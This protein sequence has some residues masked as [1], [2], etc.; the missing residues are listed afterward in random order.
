MATRTVESDTCESE[1]CAAL[2]PDAQ[3]SVGSTSSQ[4]KGVSAQ[5][6]STV[7]AHECGPDTESDPE[8]PVTRARTCGRVVTNEAHDTTS[9]SDACDI[10]NGKPTHER[11]RRRT[12]A[13]AARS[14]SPESQPRAPRATSATDEQSRQ[15]AR[16]Q[17]TVAGVRVEPVSENCSH[18]HWRFA[19][20]HT[21]EQI[22]NAKAA[23]NALVTAYPEQPAASIR[24]DSSVIAARVERRPSTPAAA[25]RPDSLPVQPALPPPQS[26]ESRAGVRRQRS[27]CTRVVNI[28]NV[29]DST[30]ASKRVSQSRAAGDSRAASVAAAPRKTSQPLETSGDSSPRSPDSPPAVEKH[31]G[32]RYGESGLRLPLFDGHDWSGFISQFEMCAKRYHWSDSV[33]VMR[34]IASIVGKARQSLSSTMM[35]HWSYFALKK[36]FET[37]YGKSQRSVPI[38]DQ[39]SEITRKTDQNLQQ[40]YDSINRVVNSADMSYE[41]RDKLVYTTFMQGLRSN[42]HMHRWVARREKRGTIDSALELAA[43]YEDEFGASVTSQPPVVTVNTRHVAQRPTQNASK[44]PDVCRTSRRV[45]QGPT[46]PLDTQITTGFRKLQKQIT[47]QFMGVNSRLRAVES[48]QRSEARRWKQ[49][50][51]TWVPRGQHRP[52]DRRYYNQ[53]PTRFLKPDRYYSYDKRVADRRTFP[54]RR[55]DGWRPNRNFHRY[56]GHE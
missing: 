1:P 51:P 16:A 46:L 25:R 21:D 22:A 13:A 4:P 34:L 42:Q 19:P 14:R 49:Q 6:R 41:K 11:A 35:T 7:D 17:P 31:S 3:Q 10:M 29:N 56:N 2:G 44:S 38:Q 55:D 9:D 52:D 30:S 33:K 37:R 45:S 32:R 36:H 15:D 53:N 26:P 27:R 47:A 48:F 8:P 23:F 50:Q 39:L 20:E 28:V 24:D 18:M 43:M 54:R 5:G 12:Q 40:Y